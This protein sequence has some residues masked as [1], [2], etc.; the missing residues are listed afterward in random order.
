V[1][2]TDWKDLLFVI[3]HFDLFPEVDT[4]VEYFRHVPK[5]H[6]VTYSHNSPIALELPGY[7]NQ[8]KS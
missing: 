7:Q 5:F 4:Y 2:I 3:G 1:V 6:Y 8:I